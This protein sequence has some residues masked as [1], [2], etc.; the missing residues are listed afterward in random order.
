MHLAMFSGRL[1]LTFDNIKG[2][3]GKKKHYVVQHEFDRCTGS[4]FMIRC[5]M[6]GGDLFTRNIEVKT[7]GMQVF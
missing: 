6:T 7:G 2:D 4:T 5:Q 3:D 1:L